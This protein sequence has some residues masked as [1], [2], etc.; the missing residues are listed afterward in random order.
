LPAHTGHAGAVELVTFAADGKTVVSVGETV[1]V[2][3]AAT[4][5]ELRPPGPIEARAAVALSRDGGTVAVGM[6]GTAV[7]R[8]VATGRVLRTLR[9]PGGAGLALAL[10]PDGRTLAVHGTEGFEP[11][12]EVSVGLWDVPTGEGPRRVG[13]Q[14][15]AVTSLVF[16]PDGTKLA[17][18]AAGHVRV[19]DVATGARL[20]EI[21]AAELAALSFS[22]DGRLLAAADLA[23][24]VRVWEVGGGKEVGRFS[25]HRSRVLATTFAPAGTTLVSAAADGTFRLWDLVS[26]NLLHEVQGDQEEV[27]AVSVAPDGRRVASAG[28]DTTVLIWDVAGLKDVGLPPA[29]PLRS[30]ELEGLWADLAAKNM[31]RPLA[32]RAMRRLA[33]SPASALPFLRQRLRPGSEIEDRVKWLIA[34]LDSDQRPVRE[35]STR[36]LQRLGRTA[37][38]ALRNALAGKPSPEARLRIEVL[39]RFLTD[40]E[41]RRRHLLPEELRLVRAAGVL[42]RIGTP[43]ATEVL[44]A[45]AAD[46]ALRSA[47]EEADLSEQ[48]LVNEAK[49]A[50][51][52]L[53]PSCGDL[54]PSPAGIAEVSAGPDGKESRQLGMRGQ[55][56]SGQ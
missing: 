47:I 46:N 4:G 39:L 52:G 25:G 6:A 13:D 18:R 8:D 33:G 36:E 24:G 51:E 7:V 3:D 29:T 30:E 12:G 5:K 20:S 41:P 17:A 42:G 23:N 28:A 14:E 37:A 21:P 15:G 19:W 50:L 16:S 43:E 40:T 34:G 31:P 26:G 32:D 22:P 27:L 35:R 53:I 1:R 48:P 56:A 44:R 49:A 54:L 55:P 11:A 45:L 38:P 9:V 2:W 10:S